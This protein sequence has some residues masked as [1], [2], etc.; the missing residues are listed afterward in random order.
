MKEFQQRAQSPSLINYTHKIIRPIQA[1]YSP[2]ST[3]DMYIHTYTREFTIALIIDRQVDRARARVYESRARGEREVDS[4]A[5]NRESALHYSDMHPSGAA[6]LA[7]AHLAFRARVLDIWRGAV[8]IRGRRPLLREKLTMRAIIYIRE[9]KRKKGRLSI[10]FG[11][12]IG[13]SSY[14]AVWCKYICM[15]V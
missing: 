4:I 11:C 5:D 9:K 2:G 12:V 3:Y 1:T 15:W 8:I 6:R 7:R 14:V 13:S 10:T